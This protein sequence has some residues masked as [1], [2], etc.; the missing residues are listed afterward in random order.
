MSSFT[1]TVSINNI[2]SLPAKARE[3]VAK[4]IW[5]L[6]FG[7]ETQKVEYNMEL[8]MITYYANGFKSMS[9]T[10]S[11]PYERIENER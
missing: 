7:W 6:P 1:Q 11:N 8:D 4:T 3:L 9:F 5:N 10:A 2:S